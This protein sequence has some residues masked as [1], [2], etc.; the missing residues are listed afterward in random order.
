MPTFK[1][2]IAGNHKPVI[3]GDDYAIWRRMMLIPFTVTIPPEEQDPSLPDNL[4]AELSGILN[5]AL[6][7]CLAW[8]K[9]GLGPPADIKQAVEQYR[10]EMDVINHWIEECC[11]NDSRIRTSPDNLYRSY[12][13]WAEDNGFRPLSS[14]KFGMKM[15]ERG[16]K[17]G[18]TGKEDFTWEF[19]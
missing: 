17:E 10:D 14:T 11:I 3:R 13:A 5:W 8:Q 6:E 16:Y 19:N 12:K 18:R 7:G 1:L 2:W 4:R 9:H 15:R